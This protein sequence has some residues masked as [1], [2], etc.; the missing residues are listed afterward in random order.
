MYAEPVQP[1][2]VEQRIA[3]LR[4]KGTP[5]PSPARRRAPSGWPP[6]ILRAEPDL[7]VIQGTVVSAE[8][9]ARQQSLEPE[10]LH[11]ALRDPSPPHQLERNVLSAFW[12]W[13]EVTR[14]RLRGI[15]RHIPLRKQVDEHLL[16]ASDIRW[17]RT[18]PTSQPESLMTAPFPRGP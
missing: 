14:H 4:R 1:D 3:E 12:F 9:V 17:R 13:M 16:G 15:G 10:G 18:A 6:S 8:H 7:L 2:L 11:P 5:W